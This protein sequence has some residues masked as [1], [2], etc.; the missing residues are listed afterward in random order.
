MAVAAKTREATVGMA[1]PSTPMR[2][3]ALGLGIVTV[4]SQCVG[5]G[6]YGKA[7]FYTKK[8]LK[9][10]YVSMDLCGERSRIFPSWNILLS[11]PLVTP[12]RRM[13]FTM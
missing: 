1:T 10:A 6:D 8:L 2:K 9:T 13:F 7:R 4:V 11:K 3:P 12:K 5:A